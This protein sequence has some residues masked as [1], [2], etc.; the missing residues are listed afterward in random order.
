MRRIYEH[1]VRTR[2]R[3]LTGERPTLDLD[4]D[5]D[6]LDGGYSDIEDLW[7]LKII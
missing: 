4:S 3:I 1:R 6:L 2:T 5:T 7:K